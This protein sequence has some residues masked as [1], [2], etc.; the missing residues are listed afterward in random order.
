MR[1]KGSSPLRRPVATL[2]WIEAPLDRLA[3]QTLGGFVQTDTRMRYR[4]QRRLYLRDGGG[5]RCDNA[6]R[7]GGDD[8]ISGRK[9]GALRAPQSDDQACAPGAAADAPHEVTSAG[10]RC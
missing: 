5:E 9:I 10:R 4:A 6:V 1:R 7:R 2:P 8:R 3:S